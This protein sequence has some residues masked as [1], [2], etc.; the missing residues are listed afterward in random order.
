[1]GLR[2]TRSGYIAAEMGAPCFV[3]QSCF[4]EAG[5]VGSKCLAGN[6]QNIRSNML[7]ACLP[8]QRLHTGS[9]LSCV[10]AWGGSRGV[11]PGNEK[12]NFDQQT[13]NLTGDEELLHSSS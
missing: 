11:L 1:M 13:V 12:A 7:G 9:N 5:F 6:K 3:P 2:E 8:P 4:S 10:Y